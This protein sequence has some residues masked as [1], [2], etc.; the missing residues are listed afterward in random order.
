MKLNEIFHGDALKCADLNGKEVTLKIQSYEVKDFDDGKKLELHFEST[1][2]TLICNKTNA[3]TV[4]EFL[5]DN[6]DMW[7]GSEIVLFPAKTDFQGRQVD[8]IRVKA[9][10]KAPAVDAGAPDE[11]DSIPF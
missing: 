4:S 10:V 6:I 11:T 8:C 1:E 9:P 3:N 7:C 5:G 2:R